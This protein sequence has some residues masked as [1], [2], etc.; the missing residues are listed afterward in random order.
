MQELNMH[1]QYACGCPSLLD[2]V[3]MFCHMY[4][5]A[6]VLCVC[7]CM[8]VCMCMCVYVYMCVYMYV[9]VCMCMYLCMCVYASVVFK[10]GKGSFTQCILVHMHKSV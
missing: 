7:V 1:K 2:S 8:Y 6:Y 5:S 3:I 10:N 4:S 9:C